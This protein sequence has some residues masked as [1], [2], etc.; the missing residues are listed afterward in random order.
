[1]IPDYNYKTHIDSSEEEKSDSDK[2]WSTLN[3]GS[4]ED[5]N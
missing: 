5:L 2:S 1:M 4:E 3:E